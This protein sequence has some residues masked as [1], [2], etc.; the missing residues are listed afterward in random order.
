ML[1][2]DGNRYELCRVVKAPHIYVLVLASNWQLNDSFVRPP[3]GLSVH[4]RLSVIQHRDPRR[5]Q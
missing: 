4:L 3:N 2:K 5:K 1:A